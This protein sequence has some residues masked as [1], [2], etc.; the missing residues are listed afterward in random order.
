MKKK[1][2]YCED[3]N[4]LKTECGLGELQPWAKRFVCG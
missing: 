2:Q 1:I 4:S 3:A